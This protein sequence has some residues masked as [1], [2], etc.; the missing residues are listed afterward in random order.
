MKKGI[1]ATILVIQLILLVLLTFTNLQTKRETF[2][3]ENQYQR[4]SAYRM[5]STFADIEHDVYYLKSKNVT[6]KTLG[7][8]IQFVND[9]FEQMF[10]MDITFNTTY[11]VIKDTR[12]EMIKEGKI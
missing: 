8:Y 7:G 4:I 5:A 9:T 6:N 10:L 3:V 2:S 11:L 1:L 12:L